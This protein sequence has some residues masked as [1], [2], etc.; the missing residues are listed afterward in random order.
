MMGMVLVDLVGPVGNPKPHSRGDKSTVLAEVEHFR[1]RSFDLLYIRCVVVKKKDV[2]K[3]EH[4]STKG[5]RTHVTC[6]S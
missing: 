5:R 6:H 1:N 4:V 3:L 2:V